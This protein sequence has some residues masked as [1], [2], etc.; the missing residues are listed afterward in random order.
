MSSFARS[1]DGTLAANRA[2]QPGSPAAE[3]AFRF[4]PFRQFREARSLVEVRAEACRL[5]AGNVLGLVVDHQARGGLD[6]ETRCGEHERGRIGLGDTMSPEM[7]VSSKSAVTPSARSRSV[8]RETRS[9]G[10]R[11]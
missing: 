4:E 1:N 11:A 2:L 7:I 6:P 3:R 8:P 9:T 10:A 5:G